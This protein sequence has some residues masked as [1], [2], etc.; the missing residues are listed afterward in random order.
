M[1]YRQLYFSSHPSFF[2]K[3]KCAYCGRWFP[4]SQI[5]VDHRISKRMGGTDDIYNLQAVCYHC[6][7][8]KRERSTDA[9]IAE[10]MLTGAVTGVFNNGIQ[11]GIKNIGKEV[12]SMAMQRFRD[13]LGIRYRRK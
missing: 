11:G 1:G 5:D 2:G 4:K 13:K 7:R 9:D 10:T 3:Y 8:S 6:N 12:G